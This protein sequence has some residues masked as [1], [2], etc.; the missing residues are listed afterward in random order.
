MN[1]R[2]ICRMVLL[3]EAMRTLRLAVLIAASLA[4]IRYTI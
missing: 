2:N 1:S 4:I 3:F